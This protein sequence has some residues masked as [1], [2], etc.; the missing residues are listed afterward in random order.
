MNLS[1]SRR[2]FFQPYVFDFETRNFHV[3]LFFCY[4]IIQIIIN[5]T[6]VQ[7]CLPGRRYGPSEFL[8]FFFNKKHTFLFSMYIFFLKIIFAPF[9]NSCHFYSDHI[10]IHNHEMN[11]YEYFPST[12]CYKF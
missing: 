3:F 5:N 1:V 12:F 7:N 11:A 2:N 4:H 10:P 9:Y 8:Y 6:S